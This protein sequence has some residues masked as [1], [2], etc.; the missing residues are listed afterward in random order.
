MG[1][2]AWRPKGSPP[3]AATAFSPTSLFA[4]GETGDWLDASDLATLF[5]NSAGT[6]P[7]TVD[8]DPVGSING[9]KYATALVQGTSAKKPVYH[10]SGGLSWLTFDSIDDF[11]LGTFTLTQPFTRISLVRVVTWTSGRYLFDGKNTDT[12]VLY[13]QTASPR[14]TIYS[15]SNGPTTTD[16]T[17]G[18]NHVVTEI[19][20]G[21]SSKIAVDNNSYSTGNP[22]AGSP[23]GFMVSGQG[24][25]GNLTSNIQ[26]FGSVVIGRVLT[27]PEIANVRTFLGTKGGLTL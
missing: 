26:W 12:A 8:G 17:V 1:L 15:G 9:K 5:Q 2:P 3:L 4:G 16:L 24:G 21:A 25:T 6:T 10:T 19:I 11:L 18:A 27:D 23:G 22:G 14:V 7:V 20:N 13:M